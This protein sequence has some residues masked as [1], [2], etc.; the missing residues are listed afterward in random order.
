MLAL[1]THRSL[2]TCLDGGGGSYGRE[3]GGG[4]SGGGGRGG[5]GSKF[6][7]LPLTLGSLR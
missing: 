3:G 5:G 4:Y 2:L 1:L 7:H 6:I